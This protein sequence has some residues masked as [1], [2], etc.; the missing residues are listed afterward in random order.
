MPSGESSVV[1]VVLGSL[2]AKTSR[3]KSGN[4]WHKIHPFR[5]NR[6][7][8]V[9]ACV[10]YSEICGVPSERGDRGV[11]YPERCSGLVCCVPLGQTLPQGGRLHTSPGCN[12]GVA[13][14]LGSGLGSGFGSGFGAE[15]A[16]G[17]WSRMGWVSFGLGKRLGWPWVEHCGH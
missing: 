15:N 6:I 5:R 17:V 7:G 9:R 14:G 8:V 4:R 12:P 13:L 10:R 2:T 16:V 1:S 3:C 11:A